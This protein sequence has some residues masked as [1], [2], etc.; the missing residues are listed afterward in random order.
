LKSPFKWQW[1]KNALHMVQTRWWLCATHE[2]GLTARCWLC[3]KEMSCS[4]RCQKDRFCL[5]C[6]PQTPG[7]C[8]SVSTS[9]KWF[10]FRGTLESVVV[11]ERRRTTL[12][13]PFSHQLKRENLDTLAIEKN[14]S[15][16]AW[17]RTTL[18]PTL[19]RQRQADFRVWDQPGLQSEF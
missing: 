5:H 17:W 14:T 13:V 2:L 7:W 15:R 19:G 9:S 10:V 18:I 4:V 12:P 1:W 8:T 11:S 6:V 16:R 3:Q